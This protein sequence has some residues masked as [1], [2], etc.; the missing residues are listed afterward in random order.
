MD[1]QTCCCT[2][3]NPAIE[4]EQPANYSIHPGFMRKN[5][6][7]SGTSGFCNNVGFSARR[8]APRAVGLALWAFFG[9]VPGVNVVGPHRSS[10]VPLWRLVLFGRNPRVT[11][12]RTCLLCA[13]AW[14]IFRHVLLPVRVQGISMEPTL[15]NGS[16][17]LINRIPYW[18]RE[19]RRGEIVAIRT[20]G[21]RV[22]YL[23]RIVALPNE[24]IEIK[25]GRVLVDGQ[26][27]VEDYVTNAHTWE[28]KPRT[29][30][31]DEY[32]V[33]GDNRSMP[34]EDHVAGVVKRT[35]IVGKS[36]Y[37]GKPKP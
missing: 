14:L 17:N 18:R 21:T 7:S 36:V 37:Q 23:K 1:S 15:R 27:L 2:V 29:L 11:I 34:M 13:V 12:V 19:P 10:A 4:R 28:M 32:F 20:T 16:V 31:P 6:G 24:T 3:F 26:P 22:M 8:L 5:T 30:G 25:A 33:L 35:R 9:I